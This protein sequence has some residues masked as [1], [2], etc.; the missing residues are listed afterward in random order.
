MTSYIV[1]NLFVNGLDREIQFD[2]AYLYVH[3]VGGFISWS[4][5]VNGVE[6]IDIFV[7][8]KRNKE[9]L[10]INF[11]TEYMNGLSG[12]VTVLNDS[13]ELKGTDRLNGFND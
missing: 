13:V 11:S 4:L 9:R 5:E 2:R 7:Q 1:K 6:Q 12:N 10:N 8:A 3:E